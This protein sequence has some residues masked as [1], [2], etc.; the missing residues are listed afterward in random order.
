MPNPSRRIAPT[1]LLSSVTLLLA[2]LSGL[3]CDTMYYK[4]M[5][6]FGVEKREGRVPKRT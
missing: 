1:R 3:G 4:T 2:S 5:K 6:R